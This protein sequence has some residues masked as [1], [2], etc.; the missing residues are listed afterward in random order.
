MPEV[1][2]DI[3]DCGDSE[4]IIFMEQVLSVSYSMS[5]EWIL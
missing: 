5:F 1:Q 3:L 4:K 2:K